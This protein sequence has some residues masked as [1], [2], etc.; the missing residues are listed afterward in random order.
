MQESNVKQFNQDEIDNDVPE[1]DNTLPPLRND[2]NEG[3]DDDYDY[4]GDAD[5]AAELPVYSDGLKE[6]ILNAINTVD[7]MKTDRESLNDRIKANRETLASAGIPKSVFDLIL[8]I[9]Q[10]DDKQR[11]IFDTAYAISRQAI[12]H[13]IQGDLFLDDAA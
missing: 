5:E 8:K 6:V 9:N 7:T 4:D 10:M 3:T 13:P 11:Q 2:F 1:V 12:G